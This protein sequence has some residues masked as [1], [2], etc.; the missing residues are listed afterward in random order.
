ML[1]NS[2]LE[3]KAGTAIN[4]GTSKKIPVLHM[5]LYLD[6][7]FIKQLKYDLYIPSN[8]RIEVTQFGNYTAVSINGSITSAFSDPVTI[9][10]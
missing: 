6:N 7:I 4:G 5:N 10:I 3:Y 8:N 1:G 2:T 9:T